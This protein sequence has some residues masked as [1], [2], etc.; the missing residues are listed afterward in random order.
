MDKSTTMSELEGGEGA[1]TG[2]YP[3]AFLQDVRMNTGMAVPPEIQV[4]NWDLLD[5]AI[6]N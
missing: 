3:S 2:L 6:F 1:I 4:L 5:D